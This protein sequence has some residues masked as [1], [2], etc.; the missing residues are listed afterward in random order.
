MRVAVDAMGGD[1]AP[2]ELVAGALEAAR[3]EPG[4]SVLLVGDQARI[5]A[6]IAAA[7]GAPANVSVRH[8][9]QQIGMGESPV[10]AL[11]KNPDASI[12][13]T[14][15][16]VASGEA[17]ACI[18]AGSTGAAVAAAMMAL[19][20]LPNVR[21]PAIAVPF[22]ARNRHGV[23]LLLDVGANP[24]C[25][26]AHLFQYAVMGSN[27]F[28]SVFGE[29]NPRV[30]LVSIGEEEGKG[31]ALVKETTKLLRAGPVQFVGN[32]EGRGLF[33]GACEVGVTDG[34]VGN[35]IL[36]AAEGFAET[37][38][39]LVSD[40]VKSSNPGL[41]KELARKVDYAEYG[42]APLLGVQGVVIICHGRS[43]R[44]AIGNAIRVGARA[45]SGHM[46]ERI[47]EG[48]TPEGAGAPS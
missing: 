37:V 48:L 16:L 26:P 9:A 3:I 11:R 12:L 44:R 18:A 29:P 13:R 23:C 42:G 35:I 6:E 33:G 47:V 34:F 19:P 22:P 46:N 28:R 39:G 17:D 41:L 8:A 45:V 40:V 43:D 1:H 2:R 10:E 38:L 25:R 15:Q 30:A 4:F 36:K 21:R 5:E 20:R 31:N 32:V 7:G 14:V 27:Y 24:A